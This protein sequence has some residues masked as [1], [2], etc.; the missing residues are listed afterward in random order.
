MANIKST[1]YPYGYDKNG[2]LSRNSK[3]FT[4][5]FNRWAQEIREAT[6]PAESIMNNVLKEA[7][8]LIKL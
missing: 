5:G 2:S 7:K 4:K 6:L 1:V 8:Q 3:R